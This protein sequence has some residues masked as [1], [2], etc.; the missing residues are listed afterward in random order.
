MTFL[1]QEEDQLRFSCGE[2]KKLGSS[3]A[4]LVD[5]LASKSGQAEGGAYKKAA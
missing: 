5:R 3:E 2:K 4:G 1:Q